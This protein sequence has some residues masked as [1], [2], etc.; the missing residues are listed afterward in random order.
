MADPTRTARVAVVCP[1][2]AHYDAIGSA[3]HDT[4]RVLSQQ[5]DFDVSVLTFRNDYV[6]VPARTVSGLAD[7]LLDPAFQAADIIIYHFG[8]YCELFDALI[9]AKGRARQFVHFHNI[10]PPQFVAP[11]QRQVIERS[12]LQV[13]NLEQADEVWADSHVNAEA[14]AT[15]GIDPTRIQVIPLAVENPTPRTL[16]GKASMPLNLLFV[17]R[18]VQSK[19][20]LDLVEAVDLV[21]RRCTVPF[22]LRLA[23]NLEWSDPTYLTRVKDAVTARKLDTTVE[24]LGTVNAEVLEDLY[25]MSHVFAIPS[26]HEGFCKPVIEAL[27]AGCVPIGY[28]SYNLPAIS[29][30]LGRMV[31]TGDTHALGAALAEVME[32]VAQSLGAPD[33]PLL[34]LDI[35]RISARAFDRAVGEYVQTFTLNRLASATLD[36]IRAMG[37]GVERNK[38]KQLAGRGPCN[39]RI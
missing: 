20:L 39:G 2:L 24:I 16:C 6:D 4:F 11:A 14:L 30:G 17:G 13:H 29:N 1:V 22:R 23:G 18:F 31:P 37:M 19:G 35:G 7:L 32:G 5:P 27:R 8:I 3:A 28:V 38:E 36:R 26:Y 25:H 33:D 12:F 9:A 15:L 10:T 34:P 21:R